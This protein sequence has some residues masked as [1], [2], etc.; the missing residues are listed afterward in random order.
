MKVNDKLLARDTMICA[1][2][3]LGGQKPIM[4]TYYCTDATVYAGD[5][6][7]MQY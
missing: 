2:R 3:L 5:T 1:T 7:S 4:L 6:F